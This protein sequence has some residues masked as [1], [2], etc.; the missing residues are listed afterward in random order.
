MGT[1]ERQGD[2]EKERRVKELLDRLAA[3]IKKLPPERL[4]ALEEFIREQEEGTNHDRDT[5]PGNQG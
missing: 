2:S 5:T 4:E 1:H 3:A